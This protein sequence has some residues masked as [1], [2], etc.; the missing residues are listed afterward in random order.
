[1]TNWIE[2][3]EEKV[4]AAARRMADLRKENKSLKTRLGK[5]EERLE[6][7]ADEAS[8][9][10]AQERETVRRRVGKLADDLEKLLEG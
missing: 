1:M 2:D 7:G 3:L 10:W 6:K 5:L 8:D 4:K 9:E